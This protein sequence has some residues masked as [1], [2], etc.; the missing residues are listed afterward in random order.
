MN[1]IYDVKKYSLFDFKLRRVEFYN[2]FVKE[3]SSFRWT[4]PGL[5]II[6][7]TGRNRTNDLAHVSLRDY[8]NMIATSL[9]GAVGT[10]KLSGT[11]NA[12]T[13]GGQ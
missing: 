12:L 8:I 9:R 11:A 10:N 3:S 13:C 1:S 2:F 5:R 4:F 6:S 7:E